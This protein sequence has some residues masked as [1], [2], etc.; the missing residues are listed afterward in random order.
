MT[1]KAIQM[2][3]T[4]L[5]EGDEL[6]PDT[7]AASVKYGL[8]LEFENPEELRQAIADGNVQFTIG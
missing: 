8:V 5:V 2:G 1:A 7:E 4:Y 3:L 6:L